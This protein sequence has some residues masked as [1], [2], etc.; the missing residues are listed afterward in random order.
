MRS[1]NEAGQKNR[2]EK[3]KKGLGARA[4][5]ADD[6]GK[7]QIAYSLACLH[8]SCIAIESNYF[9]GGIF[10]VSA[11]EEEEEVCRH[12]ISFERAHHEEDHRLLFIH[13]YCTIFQNTHASCTIRDIIIRYRQHLPIQSNFSFHSSS[14]QSNTSSTRSADMYMGI[15]A[16]G[17]LPSCLVHRD[18]S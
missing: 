11:L 9:P 17:W 8:E 16:P 18:S 12:S 4:F 6:N 14:S 5:E 13:A 1:D 15:L 10:I 3:S 7:H 2:E